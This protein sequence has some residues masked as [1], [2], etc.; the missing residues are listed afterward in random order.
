MAEP[1]ANARA[2]AP[3]ASMEASVDSS[4]FRFGLPEREYS[5]PYAD[6]VMS[7]SVDNDDD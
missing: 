6:D 3:P 4:A 1:E 5:K 7:D 2:Y